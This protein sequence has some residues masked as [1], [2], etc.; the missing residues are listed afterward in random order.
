MIV[1]WLQYIIPASEFSLINMVI[2]NTILYFYLVAVGKQ[3]PLSALNFLAIVKLAWI[4][5]FSYLAEWPGFI[6][7]VEKKI[8]L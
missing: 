2:S 4:W 5:M 3:I 7:F 6:D 1:S 8:T